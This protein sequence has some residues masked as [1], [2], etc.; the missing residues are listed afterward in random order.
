MHQNHVLSAL[1]AFLSW[2][3][4]KIEQVEK[5]NQKHAW[6]TLK[7]PHILLKIEL[8]IFDVWRLDSN[9]SF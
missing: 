5:Q 9:H 4:C 7:K 1:D 6:E 2:I 3:I 8:P